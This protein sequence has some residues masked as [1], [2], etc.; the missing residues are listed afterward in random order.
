MKWIPGRLGLRG[1]WISGW[2]NYV[3]FYFQNKHDQELADF[4]EATAAPAVETARQEV[5]NIEIEDVIE[6]DI[7]KPIHRQ[8]S[9]V[10]LIDYR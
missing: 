10:W 8:Y 6:D 1:P 9:E 5:Q 2:Y 4:V 7:I 3:H